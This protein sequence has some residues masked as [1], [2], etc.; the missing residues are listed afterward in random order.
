MIITIIYNINYISPIW[1]K[2]KRV[3]RPPS[4]SEIT[5]NVIPDVHFFLHNVNFIKIPFNCLSVKL[6]IAY[7]EAI[8]IF[9]KTIL[10]TYSCVYV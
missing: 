3:D 10:R 4:S 6:A 8:V 7:Q 5:Y 2:K 1:Q 9:K